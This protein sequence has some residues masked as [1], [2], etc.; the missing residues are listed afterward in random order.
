M[1]LSQEIKGV[2]LEDGRMRLGSPWDLALLQAG[3]VHEAD[4]FSLDAKLGGE[5]TLQWEL[6]E[7]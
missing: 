6:A 4:T 7:E 2:I 5:E 1:T 3:Q